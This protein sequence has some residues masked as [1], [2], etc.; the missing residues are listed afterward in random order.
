MTW[1]AMLAYLKKVKHPV[2][3]LLAADLQLYTEDECEAA[4]SCLARYT[5]GVTHRGEH[6]V[7]RKAWLNLQ[8]TFEARRRLRFLA[9]EN[10]AQTTTD[11]RLA[12]TAALMN[13]IRTG[14][15]NLVDELSDDTSALTLQP[16][17][18]PSTGSLSM[19]DLTSW[20]LATNLRLKPIFT[21]K[22]ILDRLPAFVRQ[23][24]K[25]MVDNFY[26]RHL[27]KLVHIPVATF[28]SPDNP[29]PL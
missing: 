2:Y 25:L 9:M 14:F 10:Y 1:L 24:C 23:N 18:A 27:Y 26:S 21:K 15:Y 7:L 5:T 3:D 13:T 6:S 11:S 16:P 19:A 28:L 4:F 8:G 12:P 29:V 17:F 22:N 20:D